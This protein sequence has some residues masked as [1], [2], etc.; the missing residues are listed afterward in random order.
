MRTVH[1]LVTAAMRKLTAI[2]Q[3]EEP[4]AAERTQGI[5]LYD[6]KYAELDG[7]GLVYWD[8]SG[9][10]EAAEI[11]ERTFGALTRIM[12]EELAPNV[13][14]AIPS[15]QDEDGTGPLSIG[16]KGMRMLRR[17]MA[18]PASGVPTKINS[19]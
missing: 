8:N 15:E 11:P 10:P 19:F 13:G 14:Q 6:E 17:I 2:D 9:D 5:A 18:R 7:E 1:E 3:N 16:N 4:S 12:A